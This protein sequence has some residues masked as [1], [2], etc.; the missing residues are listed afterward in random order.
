M[1]LLLCCLAVAFLSSSVAKAE[2][3]YPLG[4]SQKDP[5]YYEFENYPFPPPDVTIKSTEDYMLVRR[6]GSGKF[7]DVFEAVDV[8]LETQLLDNNNNNKND[9]ALTIDPRTLV[10]LKCLKPVAERKIKRELLVLQHSSKLP[11]L[12]RLL[13]VVVPSDYNDSNSNKKYQLQ[14]MPSLVLQHAG[15]DSQWLCHHYSKTPSGDDRYMTEDEMRYF[16]Y[17][18]LVALD[19]LHSSGIMHRDVKPRNVL[20]DHTDMSLM[21]IDLGLADFYLPDTKYNVR[22]ASR[23]YKSPEL[24]LGYEHYDYAIDLWGVGCILAGL[25]MRREPFF[26][27][28]V[29]IGVCVVCVC[30]LSL[31]LMTKLFSLIHLIIHRKD[32]MDQL[33]TIVAVLGT[34]DLHAYISKAKIKM[35]PEIRKVIAKYTLRDGGSKKEWSSFASPDYTPSPEGLDLLSKLLVYDHNIRLTAKQ[36]MQHSF[37]DSVRDRVDRQIQEK[38]RTITTQGLFAGLHEAT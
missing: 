14:S 17:H 23:H 12:A 10:V 25:L 37:F 33:G 24:L 27:G 5:K 18:L 6:L 15:V 31:L 35:T 36:A 30:L 21:L 34:A 1:N 29:L 13:A 7:S 11:N 26:R 32:N 28:Y 4:C 38:T 8:Q 19:H 2:Q 20:I 9:D 16:L 3:A 22:V